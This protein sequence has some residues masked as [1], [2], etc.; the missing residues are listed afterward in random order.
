MERRPTEPQ[1]G[2]LSPTR[3][4]FADP[5]LLS[6]KGSARCPEHCA[7]DG[8]YRE[9]DRGWVGRG[10]CLPAPAVSGVLDPG[11]HR[12]PELFAGLRAAVVE[13]V[14]LQQL[15]ERLQQGQFLRTATT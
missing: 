14:L 11:D 6:T 13:D 2:S 4:G 12:Q 15:E 10:W 1:V 5:G 9:L 8:A 3:A 7:G